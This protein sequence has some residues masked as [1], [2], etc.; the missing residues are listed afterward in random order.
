MRGLLWRIFDEFFTSY[1]IYAEN[2]HFYFNIIC[3][4]VLLIEQGK[5]SNDYWDETVK[6]STQV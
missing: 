3:A 2:L 6:M 5:E 1:N 4:A